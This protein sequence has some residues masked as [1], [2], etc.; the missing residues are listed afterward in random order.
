MSHMAVDHDVNMKN[1]QKVPKRAVIVLPMEEEFDVQWTG[2]K[3]ALNVVDDAWPMEEDKSVRFRVA[4][5]VWSDKA[6][7]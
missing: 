5:N 6:C 2:A 7:A 4:T 3:I 1:V